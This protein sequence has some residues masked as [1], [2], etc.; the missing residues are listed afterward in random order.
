L[1]PISTNVSPNIAPI[2]PLIETPK[3]NNAI[4][5][6]S[7]APQPAASPAPAPEASKK[8]FPFLPFGGKRKMRKTK[9]ST[10]GKKKGKKHTRR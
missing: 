5:N 8:L 3:V 7:G 2:Q 4:A 6:L 10:K 1:T 9:K